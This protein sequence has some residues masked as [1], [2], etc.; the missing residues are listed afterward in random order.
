[1]LPL[2][3]GE[4][5]AVWTCSSGQ[6][7]L[8]VGS[9]AIRELEVFRT[10]LG[11]AIARGP[12]ATILVAAPGYDYLGLHLFRESTV[13]RVAVIEFL[14]FDSMGVL[15]VDVELSADM[16]GDAALV[17]VCG[18]EDEVERLAVARVCP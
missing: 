3:S 18:G 14:E 7:A 8:R 9:G 6:L 2:A 15:A 16:V 1:M 12:G 10:P 11:H 5:V 4:L 13:E 17:R